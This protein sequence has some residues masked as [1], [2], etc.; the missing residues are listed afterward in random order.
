MNVN[1]REI[2]SKAASEAFMSATKGADD[3]S[4]ILQGAEGEGVSTLDKVIIVFSI[5]VVSGLATWILSE[6]SKPRRF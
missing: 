6:M 5:L 1:F 3:L 2:Y 4:N